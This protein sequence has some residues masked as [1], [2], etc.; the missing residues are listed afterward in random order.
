[1][2]NFWNFL[3]SLFSKIL[4]LD[5][6]VWLFFLFIGYL[7]IPEGISAYLRLKTPFYFPE[8]VTLNEIA[9]LLFS[10]ICTLIAKQAKKSF[11]EAVQN[12]KYRPLSSK[13]IE[14]LWNETLT[15]IEKVV[16]IRLCYNR[17][18][19]DFNDKNHALTKIAIDKLLGYKLIEHNPVVLGVFFM[20]QEVKMF[21]HEMIE[22]NPD[23]LNKI[24]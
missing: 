1:M 19:S 7:F 15:N 10:L 23:I 20:P 6:T 18:G 2:E 3:N 4:L 5:L 8:H 21:I 9:I 12:N 16:L 24:F 14:K 17:L 11:K 13:K 22:K